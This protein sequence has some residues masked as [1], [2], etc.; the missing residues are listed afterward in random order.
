[1]PTRS[2][3]GLC[4]FVLAAVLATGLNATVIHAEEDALPAIERCRLLCERVYGASGGD[5][6]E[7]ALAC[8]E[9]DGCHQSCKAKFGED[10]GKVRQCLRTCMRRND[11]DRESAEKPVRL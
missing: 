2:R 9:A 6:E 10:V 7:C 3:R 8:A 4:G 5:Y 1:M 11:P